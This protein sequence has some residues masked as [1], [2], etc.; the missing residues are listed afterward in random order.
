MRRLL[1]FTIWAG[2]FSASSVRGAEPPFPRLAAN[3][4]GGGQ[5][6]ED[7]AVQQQ[8]AR[9]QV[10][11]ISYWPGWE[12]A[13][14]MTAEQVIR[15]IKAINPNTQVFNYILNESVS[16]AIVPAWTELYSKL[17][18]NKW[19]LY[20]SGV[21]GSPIPSFWPGNTTLNNT[22]FTRPD[23]NGDRWVDWYA[24]WAVKKMYEPS[25]SLDG[26]FLDNVFWR[27][28]VDGDFDLDG[29]SDQSSNPMVATWQRQGLRRHFDLMRQLMPGKHQLGN[30]G[31]WGAAE[32]V[33]PELNQ[34][35]NGGLME[36]L[37]GYSWSPEEWGGWPELMRWYRKTIAAYAE[38]KLAIFHQ[39]G[40]PTDYQSFRYGFAS[41]LMDDGYFAFNSLSGYSDAPS[42]D[43]YDVDFGQ[44]TSAP[45]T[46][47]WQSGVYRR[48]FE[49][50][51]VL[52]NPKGNGVKTV[53]LEGDFIRIRGTQS[54]IVNNGQVARAVTLSDRDGI[55]LLRRNPISVT[56]PSPPTLLGIQ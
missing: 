10:A 8:L 35:L 4:L 15:N 1:I 48:D 50:A 9:G 26:F 23:A 19:Y 52:V 40:S 42:F 43:E 25:P 33:F 20:S 41:C 36:G 46:S 17:D 39:V 38:P 31:D 54:P 47:A 44:A 34:Q 7:P 11:L 32:A 2:I 22:L 56:T 28:R 16:A 5:K 12:T 14:G 18:A 27:P 29:S 3:W 49:N 53:Q 30:T 37:I 24:K 45:A 6:Y 21:A 51:I 13:H 55:I